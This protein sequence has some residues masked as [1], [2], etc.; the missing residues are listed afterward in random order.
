MSEPVPKKPHKILAASATPAIA[1][2]VRR[3]PASH[4]N[5]TTAA[6]IAWVSPDVP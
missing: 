4:S 6:I 3:R 1:A 2:S 5:V